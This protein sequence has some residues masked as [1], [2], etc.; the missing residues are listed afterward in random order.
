MTLVQ[1]SQMKTFAAISIL[2]SALFGGAEAQAA[3]CESAI[4]EDVPLTVCTADPSTEDIR[5][6]LN[7]AN[8]RPLGTFDNI[9]DHISG[10]NETLVFGMNAGMY[11]P[12][13]APVGLYVENGTT[14][15][16]IVTRE[17]PGNFGLLPNGVL[18][19]SEKAAAV[20]ESRTF[21]A[22]PSDCT[23]ATQSGP[24]LV[25]DGTL[26]PRFLPASDSR[27]RRNGVGVDQNGTLFAV[28]SDAPVNFHRFA[29][30][31]RDVLKTPN[32]L[33]LDGKV[34]RLYAPGLDRHDIG[35]PMGP[36][37]GVV[38]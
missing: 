35:F 21:E 27:F 22:A 28:I 20:I 18:C 12:D 9:A 38:E 23:Y 16:S 4:F 5:L 32:A 15:A 17:G 6:F 2:S 8:D 31:F 26:H 19:L 11:H 34:S 10:D 33:F 29:R 24:M 13:R 37:L 7:D 14:L 25:I 30:F 3:A 36:M 1:C